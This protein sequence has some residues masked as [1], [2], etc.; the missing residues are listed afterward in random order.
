MK[1]A[2]LVLL[3]CALFISN[4]VKTTKERV[5]LSFAVH[6]DAIRSP[7]QKFFPDTIKM[8]NALKVP[9]Q[10]FTV[11]ESP[12]EAFRSLV[13]VENIEIK[14]NEVFSDKIDLK[15]KELEIIKKV[16]AGKETE[17]KYYNVIVL[18]VKKIQA[19]G[20]AYI[21]YKGGLF[22]WVGDTFKIIINT[23]EVQV[24]TQLGWAPSKISPGKHIPEVKLI[25]LIF[26]LDFDFEMASNAAIGIN[27]GFNLFKDDINLK[28]KEAIRKEMHDTILPLING[29]IANQLENI[30]EYAPLG[31]PK[32]AKLIIDYSLLSKPKIKDGVIYITVDGEVK[33]RKEMNK[34]SAAFPVGT[35]PLPVIETTRTNGVTALIS[36]LSLNSALQSAFKA[37]LLHFKYP[38]F[39]ILGEQGIPEIKGVTNHFNPQN[40]FVRKIRSIFGPDPKIDIYFQA[41]ELPIVHFSENKIHVTLALEV[42]LSAERWDKKEK[43]VIKGAWES[44]IGIVTKVDFE[45]TVNLN[46]HILNAQIMSSKILHVN[47]IAKSVV[48]PYVVNKAIRDLDDHKTL[49]KI[50]NWV[51]KKFKAQI[52]REQLKELTIPVPEFQ[53]VKIEG[54]SAKIGDEFI[55]LDLQV[56]V[57]EIE[58]ARETKTKEQE[59]E[60]ALVANLLNSPAKRRRRHK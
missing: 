18:T 49:L 26:H 59:Q 3:L 57:P 36:S 29:E 2:K 12:F 39:G 47:S 6:E 19:S 28:V 24:K 32:N 31:D 48:F 11:V 8:L 34:V 44:F 30:P 10:E 55:E 45:A 42:F 16:K 50:A 35:K 40:V 52:N 22:P 54:L 46:N 27:K 5:G 1:F 4:V 17:T 33:Q 20:S 13:K 21:G 53:G 51:I 23:F 37:K 41:D 15:F 60:K 9:T 7:L 14:V 38:E 56:R 58:A 25:K 43:K